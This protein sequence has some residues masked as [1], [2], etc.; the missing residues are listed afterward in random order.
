[1]TPGGKLQIP[2]PCEDMLNHILEYQLF[3]PEIVNAVQ[4]TKFAEKRKSI[5]GSWKT[6]WR[7]QVW[8]NNN[9]G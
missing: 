7:R 4:V 9:A 1:M 3:T 6:E 8:L 5:L 2:N